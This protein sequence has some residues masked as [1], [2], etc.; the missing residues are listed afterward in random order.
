MS[1]IPV[2][3]HEFRKQ[4]FI[5]R[6]K[7][8]TRDQVSQI[9]GRR[10]VGK[11]RRNE[12]RVENTQS[13]ANSEINGAISASTFGE[14]SNGALVVRIDTQMSILKAQLLQKVD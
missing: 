1:D 13:T 14:S 4:N 5:R 12:K 6:P 10:N 11:I 8:P 3:E 2:R 9:F 7:I